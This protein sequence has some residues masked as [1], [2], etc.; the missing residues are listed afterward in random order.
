MKSTIS[1]SNKTL[2]KINFEAKDII[3]E[4][5]Q[6]LDQI[7][8]DIKMLEKKLITSALPFTYIYV[9]SSE[10][11]IKTE[12][13]EREYEYLKYVDHTDNCLVFGKNS[14]GECRLSHSVYSTRGWL[15]RDGCLRHKDETVLIS[16]R[17][18]IETKAHFRVTIEKELASFF[19]GVI[20]ALKNQRHK[21]NVTIYS[22]NHNNVYKF[23]E[24]F[25][26]SSNEDPIPF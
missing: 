8:E 14:S 4:H 11:H 25:N 21:E 24:I 13:S 2:Q 12:W 16:Y 19:E 22:P 9:I 3:S 23:A 15:E 7:S 17:P 26:S 10:E 1:F 5:L 20:S 6:N 18:L